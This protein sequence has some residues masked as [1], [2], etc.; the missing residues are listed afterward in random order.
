MED[1]T[2]NA[3]HIFPVVASL[4]KCYIVRLW[5]YTQKYGRMIAIWKNLA[6]EE[7][8]GRSILV[9]QLHFLRLIQFQ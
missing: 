4:P 3:V 1:Y 5:P 9:P 6:G 7:K 2:F 8:V